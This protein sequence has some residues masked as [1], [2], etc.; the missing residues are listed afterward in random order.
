MRDGVCILGKILGE[1]ED[2]GAGFRSQ[3]GGED[4]VAIVQGEELLM[5]LR[6]ASR[7]SLSILRKKKEKGITKV[8]DERT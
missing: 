5:S 8:V 4:S 7:S 1:V 2:K 3:D 6:S